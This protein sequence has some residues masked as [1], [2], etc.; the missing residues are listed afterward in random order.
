MNIPS[1]VAPVA[2]RSCRGIFSS[3][4]RGVIAVVLLEPSEELIGSSPNALGGQLLGLLFEIA[5]HAGC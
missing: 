4:I 1:F 5:G 3:P 2:C